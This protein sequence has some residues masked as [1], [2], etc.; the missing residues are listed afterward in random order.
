MAFLKVKSAAGIA[1]SRTAVH[2]VPAASQI[3]GSNQWPAG[4]WR[5]RFSENSLVSCL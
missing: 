2:G 5:H 3:F 1:R 4:R